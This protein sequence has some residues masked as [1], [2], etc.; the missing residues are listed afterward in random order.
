MSIL[1]S[2]SSAIGGVGGG[3]AHILGS[4]LTS[5]VGGVQ[6]AANGVLG[7]VTGFFDRMMSA[8]TTFI[9][10]VR[11]AVM[12]LWEAH[13]IIVII[14][15]ALLALTGAI[16]A[17]AAIGVV[18]RLFR[19]AYGFMADMIGGLIHIPM[20]LIGVHVRG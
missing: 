8:V 13:K 20:R 16:W 17:P 9:D 1:D 11:A 2:I 15:G 5:L 10:N 4:T 6:G 12:R 3:A 7:T 19:V 14:V 18:K